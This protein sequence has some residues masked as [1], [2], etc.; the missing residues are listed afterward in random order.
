MQASVIKNV[1]DAP[2]KE[3]VTLPV[4][5]VFEGMVKETG[6]SGREQEQE[7]TGA[8]EQGM[9]GHQVYHFYFWFHW[10]FWLRPNSKADFL[11][12]PW[13]LGKTGT[14]SPSIM[15]AAADQWRDKIA[16]IWPPS[17]AYNMNI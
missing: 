1:A 9:F 11:R 10:F 14:A 17:S 6:R 8:K 3:L 5:I 16:T 12:R 4:V 7:R 13:T 2:T 15:P